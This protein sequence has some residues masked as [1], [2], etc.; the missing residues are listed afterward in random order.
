MPSTTSSNSSISH[1]WPLTA[2]GTA[3]SLLAS[4]ASS[5]RPPPSG[6]VLVGPAGSG[7]TCLARIFAG[8]LNAPLLR[9]TAAAL[10]AAH[11]GTELARGIDDAF[12]RASQTALS[13]VSGVA[14]LFFD[15]ADVT[16][17]NNIDTVEERAIT[18]D[19][20]RALAR[21]R[22]GV[23]ARRLQADT[24]D[25]AVAAASPIVWLVAAVSD[26]SAA[27]AL[28]R[29]E[30]P[31]VVTAGT[32]GGD[33][34][35]AEAA[36]L[37]GG[38]DRDT[39]ALFDSS[40]WSAAL[41]NAAGPS[42]R[43]GDAAAI[44]REA[45]NAVGPTKDDTVFLSAVVSA[46]SF[47]IPLSL[48]CGGSF[49]PQNTKSYR[50]ARAVCTA[51]MG[52]SLP[53]AI[54]AVVDWRSA[55]LRAAV[56]SRRQDFSTRRS[57]SGWRGRGWGAAADAA[58][59]TAAAETTASANLGVGAVASGLAAVLLAVKPY[60][61]AQ[62]G[63]VAGADAAA[64]E[65]RIVLRASAVAAEAATRNAPSPLWA[66]SAPTGI[67]LFGPPGTGKTLLARAAAS[68]L[69]AR[70][71][72]VPLPAI[73]SAGVGDS[74]R[75]LA[76][77]FASARA[78]A[79]AV[80]FFDEIDALFPRKGGGGGSRLA[81][82]LTYALCSLLDGA[83]GA[84]VVVLAATN[85]PGTLD[86]ALLGPGR[87]DRVIHVGLPDASARA[88]LFERL[89]ALLPADSPARAE[90]STLAVEL[91]TLTERFSGADLTAL[92]GRAASAALSRTGVSARFSA[93]FFKSQGGFGGGG[94]LS[95]DDDDDDDDN[96]DGG[97]GCDERIG[98]D[99]IAIAIERGDLLAALF[100]DKQ[101]GLLPMFPS[102]S[103]VLAARLA[104]W[105]P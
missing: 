20:R 60:E 69:G 57:T 19:A 3:G 25:T 35:A 63:D 70:F 104:K 46:T 29:G 16:F 55:A 45:F 65:I 67:L 22:R 44:I 81:A 41:A 54:V 78:A 28:F 11:A 85:A 8:S 9:V 48:I 73:V 36:A 101:A 34:L 42:L 90:R 82:T 5:R 99:D 26:A 96:D 50:D 17:L 38:V 88:V 33:A 52:G 31:V 61:S 91:A 6:L 86:A 37:R 62:W 24:I 47:H 7:K 75:A 87:F 98:S 76:A 89:L 14:V 84:G 80:L 43:A 83:R 39:A 27:L 105:R 93:S 71:I 10:R 12:A 2:C 95:G 40:T 1:L 59:V 49:L 53:A 77:V 13:S 92:V 51:A 74:E 103:A 32:V 72:C 66:R 15:D 102:V 30:P 68:A 21:G 58:A 94:G 23:A 18:A 64:A 97:V 79:P 100:G 4:L 56:A